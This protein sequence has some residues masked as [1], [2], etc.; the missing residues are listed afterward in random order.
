VK[1][2]LVGPWFSVPAAHWFVTEAGP[3]GGA[4]HKYC[5]AGLRIPRKVEQV[6]ADKKYNSWKHDHAANSI[7][8][9]WSV[10]EGFPHDDFALAN[11]KLCGTFFGAA[12]DGDQAADLATGD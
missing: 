9:L 10:S 7:R 1:E 12:D 6:G 5:E 11:E 2:L 8:E 3:H 4:S